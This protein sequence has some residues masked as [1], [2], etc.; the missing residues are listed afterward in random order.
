MSSSESRSAGGFVTLLTLPSIGLL[1]FILWIGGI[2]ASTIGEMFSS[3]TSNANDEPRAD[4]EPGDFPDIAQPCRLEKEEQ[5]EA[6][7]NAK[8]YAYQLL[9]NDE[10]IDNPDEQFKCLDELWIGES[11][12]NA[13]AYND[14]PTDSGHARGIPQI[15]DGLYPEVIDMVGDWQAQVDWG[16]NYIKNRDEYGT[17]CKTLELWNSRDPHWY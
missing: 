15:M 10:D 5:Q 11:N 8:A 12:W 13:W 1:V 17:P 4:I 16:Y 2:N 6:C 9:L 7:I 14:E 3:D